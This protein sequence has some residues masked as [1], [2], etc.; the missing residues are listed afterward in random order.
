MSGPPRSTIK[1]RFWPKVDRRG[2]RECWLWTGAVTGNGYD[3]GYLGRTPASGHGPAVPAVLAHRL[4]WE[5]HKGAIPRGLCVLHTCDVPRCVNPAHLFV[6]T[7]IDNNEDRDA[8][9]RGYRRHGARN[10][11]VKL[12]PRQVAEIRGR[13]VPGVISQQTLADEY[14]VKQA[15]I[16]RIVR[17]VSYL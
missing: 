15:Q 13:Y 1:D 8:K 10:P 7:R 3:Y 2:P 6:G 5:I 12:T 4:S 14:G 17:G 11:N 9:G 16:S